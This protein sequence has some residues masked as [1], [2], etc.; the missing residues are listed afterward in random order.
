MLANTSRSIASRASSKPLRRCFSSGTPLNAENEEGRPYLAPA[1]SRM[2]TME[3]LAAEI[4][5]ELRIQASSFGHSEPPVL[6]K[7]TLMLISTRLCLKQTNL[8]LTVE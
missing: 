5:V 8:P 2:Q 3:E 7:I 1:P 6:L 4:P